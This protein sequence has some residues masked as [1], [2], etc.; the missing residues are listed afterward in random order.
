MVCHADFPNFFFG[1]E[2]T[3][4]FRD[5]RRASSLHDTGSETVVPHFVPTP[6]PYAVKEIRLV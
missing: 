1:L 4:R 6:D 3:H 2:L 5:R